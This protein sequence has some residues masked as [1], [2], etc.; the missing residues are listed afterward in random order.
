MRLQEIAA[1]LLV[2]VDGI[3]TNRSG[4]KHKHHKIDQAYYQPGL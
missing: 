1:L 4:D 3:A 2:A